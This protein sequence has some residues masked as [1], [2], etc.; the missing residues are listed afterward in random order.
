M[1]YARRLPPEDLAPW[2]THFWMVAWDLRGLDPYQP[3]T[4]MHP[5][6][7]TV[8]GPEGSSVNGVFTQKFTRTLEGQAHVFGIKF[9]PGGFRSILGKPVASIAN[10]SIAA[11][12][13]VGPAIVAEMEDLAEEQALINA[14]CAWLREV[15]P[16]EPDP[17]ARETATLVAK[18]L[19]DRSLVTV[20]ALS[21]STGIAVRSLQ[22]LFREYVGVPPKWVI[23]R[24]RL[25]ELV[26]RLNAGSRLDWARTAAELGYFDQAHLIN[27]FRSITGYT[28]LQYQQRP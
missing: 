10:R 6:V 3:E 16:A 8:F 1:R 27:D 11:S 23:R 22:K 5:N 15:L 19:E 24:Y 21:A 13:I 9:Q 12:K 14:A 28:P 18:I 20:D 4:V 26:E 7:Q 2:V 25:H 17:A